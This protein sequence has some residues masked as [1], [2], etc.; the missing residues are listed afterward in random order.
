MARAKKHMQR[1]H[2]SYQQNK[3]AIFNS[4]ERTNYAKAY[5]KAQRLSFGQSIAGAFKNLFKKAK[6]C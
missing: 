5:N 2:R 4:F 3:A 6:A 1:S